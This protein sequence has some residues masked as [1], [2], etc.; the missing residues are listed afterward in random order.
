MRYDCVLLQCSSTEL[1]ICKVRNTIKSRRWDAVTIGFGVRKNPDLTPLFEKLVNMSIQEGGGEARPPKMIF[2]LGPTN[3]MESI[4][5]V[6]P[7][8]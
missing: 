6:F 8:A 3:V 2:P 4:R 7:E 1:T 5:R